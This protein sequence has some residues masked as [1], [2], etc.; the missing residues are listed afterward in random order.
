MPQLSKRVSEAGYSHRAD[1][2]IIRSAMSL[3]LLNIVTV[4]MMVIM[5]HI[6]VVVFVF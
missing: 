5:Y 4:V 3:L 2:N 1:S 6:K